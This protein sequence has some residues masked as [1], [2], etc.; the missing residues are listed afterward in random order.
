MGIGFGAFVLL[1]LLVAA[2]SYVGSR[3]ATN[4]INLTGNVRM[5]VALTA[6]QAQTDLLRMMS[7]IRGYLALGDREILG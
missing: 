3:A 7:D 6:S 2:S 4:K 5:P 1:A